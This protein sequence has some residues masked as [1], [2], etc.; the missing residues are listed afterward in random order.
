VLEWSL[1]AGDPTD[2]DANLAL[3][4]AGR[5]PPPWPWGT[6][7]ID[8]YERLLR[9]LEAH[10]SM[11]VERLDTLVSFAEEI[12]GDPRSEAHD[13]SAV[14]RLLADAHAEQIYAARRAQLAKIRSALQGTAAFDAEASYVLGEPAP[15]PWTDA[16]PRLAAHL[17]RSRLDL[18]AQFRDGLAANRALVGFGW[19]DAD[20][21]FELAWRSVQALPAPVA[22]QIEVRNVYA[23]EDATQ[24][25][26]GPAAPGW[27]T[28]GRRPLD[29]ADPHAR[30]AALGWALRSP[31]LSL[32]EGARALT[33]TLGL[34]AGFDPA[35]FL[36]ALGL[37][38]GDRSGDKLARALEAALVV[39]AS[40]AKGW[41]ALGLAGARLAT[42]AAGDDYWSIR[43][44]SRALAEDRPALQLQLAIGADR[45]AIAPIPGEAQAWPALRLTLRPRWDD[46]ARA[47]QTAI[48][49]FAPLVLAAVHLE[50]EVSGLAGLRLQQD[51]RLLDPRKPFE[52]FGSRPAVGARLY[53]EHPELTRS[54][55]DWLRFDVEWMGLPAAALKD[56]Y[57]NYPGLAGNSG[58]FQARLALVDRNLELKLADLALFE[59]QS[60]KTQP[61]RKLAIDN[62]P[63]TLQQ[64]APGFIYASR[65]D[66]PP[67]G[68]VRLAS[69]H[70]RWELT[71]VDF[72]HGSYPALAAGKAR[73][74]AVA[75]AKGGG[76]VDASAYRVDPPY[77]PTIKRLTAAYAAAVEIDPAAAPSDHRLLHVHPFGTSAIDADLPT[78][79]P[80]YEMAGELY[81]G[82]RGLRPPQHL[83]L[84][85]QL[86]EGTSDP[87]APPDAI[88]WAYL[89]GDRFEDLSGNGIVE[90]ATQR[91]TSSGIVELALPPASP[92]GR[93]PPD[94]Y[95]LRI[96]IPHDARSACDTVSIRAQAVSVRFDD[97]GNAPAH[98]E[99][100]LPVGS[101]QRML[102]PDAGIAKVEQPYSSTGGKPA[103][104]PEQLDT[105]VSER[106]RHKDRAL[107]AWDHERLVLHAFPQIY[108]ARCMAAPGGVDVVVIPD[109]RALHPSDTFA[110][111]APANLLAAIQGYLAA[112]APAS[113]RVRVRNARYV[114]VQVR[115]GVRFRDGI[116]EGFAQRRLN[117]ELVRFLSPW[118]F[119]E[120]AEITIGG[121]IYANSILDFV[122]RRDYV[123]YVA[124]IKLFRSADGEDYDL[125]PPVQGE[126]HV[127]T[128][129]PD[130]VLVAARQHYFDVIPDTGF[131]QVSFTGI[132]YTR[133]ELDFIVG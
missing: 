27:K 33:L 49:A 116:D 126:Y 21:L 56:H 41:I 86:A 37:G 102:A 57:F 36:A 89:S 14:D 72:G 120:G 100:P 69:R 76:N 106:L 131:Q 62:L 22:Q 54:R 133:L 45:D 47:W 1:P 79:L 42:G 55:L 110:P 25:K 31:L 92:G 28:F 26:D 125:V 63:G 30:G 73:E 127:A 12:A 52:P 121:R 64:N 58:V 71:P 96:A 68:D 115:L 46:K 23:F 123:D 10:L 61:T 34:R 29:P 5:W 122:D 107:T 70:L 124:E 11:V 65:G 43:G 74:L 118:A 90:D 114:S 83:A 59:D 17:D 75:L 113:A 60:G 77:T 3:A 78:L 67:A 91:L 39:E 109:I 35:G 119:D 81:L 129:R 97:R 132:N 84:L 6:K 38:A 7:N 15:I 99:Q 87:D 16:R 103:E 94:L 9:R 130:Q 108:K 44:V 18:L 48:E 50:V 111:R 8:E 88:T 85:L 112:R 101:I 53:V 24:I 93:L 40:T 80:R 51:D 128:D 104:R 117:D 105:R 82:V 20:R 2:F 95:W 66:L 13:W 19:T 98:Y 32:A 4:L